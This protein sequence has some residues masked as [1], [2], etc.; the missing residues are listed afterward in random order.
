MEYRP[1]PDRVK[2]YAAETDRGYFM[3]WCPKVIGV[4]PLTV[5]SDI[6]GSAGSENGESVEITKA[7]GVFR[8]KLDLEVET[9]N[10]STQV[11]Q[12]TKQ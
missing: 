2:S 3:R 12:V 4:I 7:G 6:D 11:W 5:M 8:T 1:G 9:N 10:V